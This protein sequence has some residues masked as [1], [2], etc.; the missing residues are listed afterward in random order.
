[1]LG[2]RDHLIHRTAV[3]LLSLQFN[4]CGIQECSPGYQYGFI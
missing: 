1:M 2:N 4:H 3:S